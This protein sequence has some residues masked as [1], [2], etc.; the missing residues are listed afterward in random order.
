MFITVDH[1]RGD[2]DE[3]QWT[4]HG[5]KIP[6]AHEIWFAVLAPGVAAKGE[7][8]EGMQL[9]QKQFAQTIASL[10]GLTFEAEHPI[11]EAISTI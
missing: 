7:M 4:S 2:L 11:G 6:D 5:T 8:K 10:M 1:G 9:Y 3:S